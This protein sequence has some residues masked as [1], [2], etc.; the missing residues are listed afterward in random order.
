MDVIAGVSWEG[1]ITEN[2]GRSERSRKGLLVAV[3]ESAVRV[4]ADMLRAVVLDDDDDEQVEDDDDD[5]AVL[6]LRAR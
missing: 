1:S 3:A 4:S 2:L 5:E 6:V